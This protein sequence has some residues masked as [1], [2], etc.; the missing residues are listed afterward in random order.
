[1]DVKG[2]PET[3]GVSINDEILCWLDEQ[4]WPWLKLIAA[5]LVIV[6]TI[7]ILIS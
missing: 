5:V 1:M 3:R 6:A 2:R 4:V 7:K